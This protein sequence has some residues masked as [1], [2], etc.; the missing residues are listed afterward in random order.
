MILFG[1]QT[2]CRSQ[3][4]LEPWRLPFRRIGNALILMNV[5]GCFRGQP[6]DPF[7]VGPVDAETFRLPDSL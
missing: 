4:P 6:P 7:W 3:F 5:P 2:T 1:A